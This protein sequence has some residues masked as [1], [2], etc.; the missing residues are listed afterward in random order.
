[1]T[2]RIASACTE[3]IVIAE[4]VLTLLTHRYGEVTVTGERT[5]E[6]KCTDLFGFAT[7]VAI[8]EKILR[9]EFELSWTEDYTATIRVP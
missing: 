2:M 8:I 7:G 5:L 9:T 3:Y 4:R 1:M 6:V